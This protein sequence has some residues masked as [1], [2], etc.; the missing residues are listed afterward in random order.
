MTR[1]GFALSLRNTVIL[2]SLALGLG[3]AA[4]EESKTLAVTK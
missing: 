4:C 2:V 1:L 3:L